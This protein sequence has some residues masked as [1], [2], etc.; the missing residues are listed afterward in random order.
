MKRERERSVA[1]LEIKDCKEQS[2]AYIC[3]YLISLSEDYTIA[4]A[5][6]GASQIGVYLSW[7]HDPM[8]GYV[9]KEVACNARILIR[10]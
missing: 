10:R 6:P 3:T 2:R 5:M 1:N 9:G 4:T 7:Q 8:E